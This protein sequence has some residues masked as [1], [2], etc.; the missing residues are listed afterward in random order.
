MA[1]DQGKHYE[2]YTGGAQDYA[3]ARMAKRLVDQKMKARQMGGAP[4]DMG[5]EPAEESP[6]AEASEEL[7]DAA[8]VASEGMGE[9]DGDEMMSAGEPDGDEAPG[10]KITVELTPE[11]LAHIKAMRAAKV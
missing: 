8:P 9:P 7:A 1:Y 10:G 2:E 11:E 4:E 3:H 6:M 5:G